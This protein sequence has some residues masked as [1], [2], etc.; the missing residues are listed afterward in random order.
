MRA[1]EHACV[2]IE[3]DSMQSVRVHVDID[4]LSSRHGGMLA[5]TDYYFE[6]R[7]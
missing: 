6:R 5:F 3:I 7:R 4:Q 1:C 2:F